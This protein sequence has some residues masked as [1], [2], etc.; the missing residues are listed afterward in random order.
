MKIT[1]KKFQL[2]LLLKSVFPDKVGF[3]FSVKTAFC[4]FGW[5]VV[6]Q[7]MVARRAEKGQSRAR[8]IRLSTS[9]VGF[10]LKLWFFTDKTYVWIPT[11][12]FFLSWG[13]KY[14]D[15]VLL[16]SLRRAVVFFFFFLLYSPILF[17][18]GFPV[19]FKS[20]GAPCSETLSVHNQRENCG[21]ISNLTY[22][23]VCSVR[24]F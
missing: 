2:L 13:S 14:I 23:S 10:S 9:W 1:Y 11:D 17:R 3:R 21:L 8:K 4:G 19:G 7:K 16:V 22:I 20:H 15:L 12:L 18:P 24:I 5:L 6:L